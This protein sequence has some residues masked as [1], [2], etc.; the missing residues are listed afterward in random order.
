MPRPTVPPLT[1]FSGQLPEI[2]SPATWADRTPPFWNWVT[3]P[4]YTNIDAVVSYSEGAMDFIDAA[5]AGA[6][7]IV[8]SVANIVSGSTKVG[9]ADKLDGL[10]SSQFLRADINATTSGIFNV[11]SFIRVGYTNGGNSD[12]NFFDTS[13]NSFRT[14]RWSSAKG[15]WE[16]EDIDTVMKKIWH[17]GNVGD[18]MRLGNSYGVNTPILAYFDGTTDVVYGTTLSGSKLRPCSANG[19]FKGGYLSGTYQSYCR[20]LSVANQ[21]TDAD[22]AGLFVRVV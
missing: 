5:L 22:G 15:Y 21:T 4:G 8:G 20:V 6:E 9:D 17:S 18:F 2:A 16:L 19:A 1:P 11:N 10:D 3:G 7:T 14:F 12:I 13:D